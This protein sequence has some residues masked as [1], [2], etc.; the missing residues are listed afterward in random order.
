MEEK[1]DAC[2]TKEAVETIYEDE[3]LTF[4]LCSLCTHEFR[5]FEKE[6]YPVYLGNWI[7]RKQKKYGINKSECPNEKCKSD[8]AKPK[9]VTHRADKS[10][11]SVICKKCGT[12]YHHS[13]KPKK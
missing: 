5:M 12:Q 6:Y 3:K 11:I 7:Y 10:R 1:C 13:L 9:H 8:D 4:K 2:G